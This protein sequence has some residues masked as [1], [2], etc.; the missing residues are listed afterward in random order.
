MKSVSTWIVTG[1]LA[2][3]AVAGVSAMAVADSREESI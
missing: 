2:A 1:S 3:V